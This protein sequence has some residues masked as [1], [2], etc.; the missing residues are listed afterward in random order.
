MV[1]GTFSASKNAKSRERCTWILSA[2]LKGTGKN[3][4]IDQNLIKS[5]GDRVLLTK[6]GGWK[7]PEENTGGNGTIVLDESSTV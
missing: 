2:D 6:D 4:V 1:A 3:G 5:D 7:V